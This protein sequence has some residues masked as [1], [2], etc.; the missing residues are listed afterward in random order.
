MPSAFADCRTVSDI[1]LVYLLECA[2]TS[3][4]CGITNNLSHRLKAH[5][6]GTAS[7]YTAPRLPVRLV[8]AGVF[9]DKST[10][11]RAEYQIK[12]ARQP[13]KRNTLLRL[14]MKYAG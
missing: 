13:N 14:A 5:N 2:D 11:L 3:I 7:K 1:W 9:P 10:A 4:Y 12:Q 8:L 6:R